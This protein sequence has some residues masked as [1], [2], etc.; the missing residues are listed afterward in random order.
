MSKGNTCQRL[1][2]II[3]RRRSTEIDFVASTAAWPRCGPC[4]DHLVSL[5]GDTRSGV[6]LVESL[7][8]PG[9]RVLRGIGGA[10]VLAAC[11]HSGR[12]PEALDESVITP[13]A[14]STGA[15]RS[16]EVKARASLIPGGGRAGRGG[17]SGAPRPGLRPRAR[18]LMGGATPRRRPLLAPT[19][20]RA[21][22]A[23][24]QRL[25]RRRG[26]S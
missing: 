7:V 26:S 20:L 9:R 6:P 19:V 17:N 15:A 4:L 22:S 10:S 1:H 14:T 18:G 2:E 3:P 5:A 8:V 23:T 21:T 25:R 11:S 24:G 12:R 16:G 13:V